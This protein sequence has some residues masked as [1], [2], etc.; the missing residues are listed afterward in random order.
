MGCNLETLEQRLV[1]D[2]PEEVGIEF[3]VA[4]VGS[5]LVAGIIDGALIVL[6]LLL[7]VVLPFAALGAGG[8][9][10]NNVGDKI[11]GR[12]SD[13]LEGIDAVAF[14]IVMLG[15]FAIL[16]GYYVAAELVTDGRSPGKRAVGLRVLRTDGFPI[17]V[18]ESVVRNL[19]RAIDVIPGM[20]FVG[21]VTM[22][23]SA[24]S[25]R[26][27]DLAAGTIVVRERVGEDRGRIQSLADVIAERSGDAHTVA[28]L[29]PGETQLLIGYLERAGGLEPA[30]RT[31][32]AG[33]IAPIVRARLGVAADPRM[34]DEEWL[35]TLG[36]MRA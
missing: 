6:L 23:I 34:S 24:R 1:V 16:W 20:Y 10:V 17:S 30:A 13:L 36:R 32:L 29:G 7:V 26:L 19:V 31:A 14:A 12:S 3:E 11:V 8:A 25:Q 22:M 18:A 35:E 28:G 27:G 33:Q 15:S 21:L 2:T 9:L 4:G 5:R